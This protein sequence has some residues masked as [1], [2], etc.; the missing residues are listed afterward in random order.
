MTSPANTLTPGKMAGVVLLSDP[1]V[2]ISLAD[3]SAV[4]SN[5]AVATIVN[6]GSGTLGVAYVA[7]G[8][9]DITV[10]QISDGSVRAHAV[11]CTGGTPPPPPPPAE[12][13]WALGTAV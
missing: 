13:D 4:S 7:D 6:A 11:T 12:W 3:Y 10:T 2:G 8:V 9:A 1:T 5:P